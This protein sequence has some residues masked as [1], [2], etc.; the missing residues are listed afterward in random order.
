MV[1][2][3]VKGAGI[4]NI[5]W[6]SEHLKIFKTSFLL[7]ENNRVFKWNEKKIPREEP[8]YTI[9]NVDYFCKNLF[10]YVLHI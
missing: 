3:L 2:G 4:L 1:I 9:I 5:K 7:I 6:G 8:I 10:I